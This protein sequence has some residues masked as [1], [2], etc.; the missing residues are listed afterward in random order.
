V[1]KPLWIGLRYLCCTHR[2]EIYPIENFRESGQDMIAKRNINIVCTAQLYS[3][4][5]VTILAQEH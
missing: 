5:G 2:V 4:R 3:R 1:V